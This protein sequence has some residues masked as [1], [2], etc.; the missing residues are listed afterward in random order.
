MS[1][2]KRFQKLKNLAEV[3]IHA[4]VFV[5]TWKLIDWIILHATKA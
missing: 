3:F 4:V 5:L 2:K 1:K